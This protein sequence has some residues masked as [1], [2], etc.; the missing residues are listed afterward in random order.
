M[1]QTEQDHGEIINVNEEAEKPE[2]SAG[3]TAGEASV[4]AGVETSEKEAKKEALEKK[5]PK[6]KASAK[7]NSEETAS[8]KKYVA[9][10]A[11]TY[12][13]LKDGT[14][15]AE[16]PNN[17]ETHDSVYESTSE[18][19]KLVEEAKVMG[20][21]QD[22]ATISSYV[23]D[24]GKVKF[25]G[26]G[27]GTYKIEETVVPAGYN[28]ADDIEFTIGYEINYET[29]DITWNSNNDKVVPDGTTK[30]FDTTVV[31]NKG[32]ELPSTGGMGTTIFYVIGG[33]LVLAAAI[34][35]ISK[36]RVQQ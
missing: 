12:Y 22:P 32:T 5:A 27:A 35:L 4:E 16:A 1:S 6:K 8:E 13:K 36:R 17:D 30:L 15:T 23:D 10:A 28:K 29:L 9:D 26:L 18:T 7:K 2:S 3:E 31:N 20:E 33:I 19:Y 21:G 24:E 34:I 14:Y 11:G 25:T